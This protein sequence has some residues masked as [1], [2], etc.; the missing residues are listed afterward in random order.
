[1]LFKFE[2]FYYRLDFMVVNYFFLLIVR[3]GCRL[4]GEYD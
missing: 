1:M 3:Y 4:G 2:V